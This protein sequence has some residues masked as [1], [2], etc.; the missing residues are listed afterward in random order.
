MGTSLRELWTVHALLPP[1][2]PMAAPTLA[3]SLFCAPPQGRTT[4]YLSCPGSPTLWL[5]MRPSRSS[6]GVVWLNGARIQVSTCFS[7]CP[8]SSSSRII[9][10]RSFWACGSAGAE[11]V[12]AGGRECL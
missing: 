6:S 11:L 5:W 2:G 1:R 9:C 4:S 3:S 12:G 8:R 10:V 7:I